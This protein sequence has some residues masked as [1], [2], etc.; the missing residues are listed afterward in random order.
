MSPGKH[1][2]T[3][4]LRHSRCALLAVVLELSMAGAP[5]L[6][7][8]ASGAPDKG[9]TE[10]TSEQMRDYLS[11]RRR[12]GALTG[13]ILGGALTAH[14]AGTVIGS[15]IGFFVGKESMFNEDKARAQRQQ[16]M[17]ARRDIIPQYDGGQAAPSLSFTHPQA[18]T[19]SA[20]APA[21][22]AAAV[23]S[24]ALLPPLA[25]PAGSVSALPMAAGMTPAAMGLSREQ[26][27]A[28]CG[29]GRRPT[30]SRLGAL[31]FYSESAAGVAAAH[32]PAAPP[33]PDMAPAP[34]SPLREQI[35]AM[36]GGGKRPADPRLA[37]LC[38]YNQAD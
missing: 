14:P 31:C 2:M 1:P 15:L 32:M 27:A 10:Q 38:F 33:G 16:A 37:T 11:D 34:G 8:D 23:T 24:L 20:A 36:C 6:A 22:P 12:T 25:A 28:I 18:I 35:A 5:A 21:R 19:F 17:A 4:I 7:D 13:M 9:L 30:D 29:G 26:I 3:R